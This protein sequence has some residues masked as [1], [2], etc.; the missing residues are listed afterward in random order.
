MKFFWKYVIVHNSVLKNLADILF[1]Q[2]IC[3]RHFLFFLYLAIRYFY[4]NQWDSN[5]KL[6]LN[7]ISDFNIN[8]NKNG[9]FIPYLSLI[10]LAAF[11]Q[12]REKRKKAVSAFHASFN[13]SDMQEKLE[14]KPWNILVHIHKNINYKKSVQFTSVA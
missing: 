11:E 3:I 7:F 8:T 13:G 6:F 12:I 4:F 5:K 10:C 9:G 2:K 14:Y 1:F